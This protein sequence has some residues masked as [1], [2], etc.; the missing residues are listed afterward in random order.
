MSPGF[1][2]GLSSAGCSH[3]GF[4]I[5]LLSASSWLSEALAVEDAQEGSLEQLAAAAGLG[6]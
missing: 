3:W 2:G 4:L 5:H 1:V 6:F